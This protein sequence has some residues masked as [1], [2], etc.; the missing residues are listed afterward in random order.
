MV[1]PSLHLS[2][3][4]SVLVFFF[5]VIKTNRTRVSNQIFCCI[6]LDISYSYFYIL[7]TADGICVASFGS[8]VA[9]A[10]SVDGSLDDE[11]G[12]IV[13]VVVTTRSDTDVTSS[14]CPPMGDTL[15]SSGS[16]DPGPERQLHASLAADSVRC[17]P[18]IDSSRTS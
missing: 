7:H 15:L 18:R 17:S 5:I 14:W 4:S 6:C 11:A 8:A 3:L 16:K 9:S 10:C 12:L 2:S 13:A 1:L